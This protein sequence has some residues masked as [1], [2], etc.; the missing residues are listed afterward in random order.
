MSLTLKKIL[1][2]PAFK[3][4]AVLTG[5]KGLSRAVTSVSFVDAPDGSDWLKGGEIL[6]TSGY[7]LKNDLA[8]FGRLIGN[9][10][11]AKAAALFIKMKGFCGHLPREISDI[12]DGLNFPIIAMPLHCTYRDV[13]NQVLTML[14]NEH[15]RKLEISGTIHRSFIDLILNGGGMDQIIMLLSQL[16][17]SDVAYID[18]KYKHNYISAHLKTFIQD[19]SELNFKKLLLKYKNYS[20]KMDRENYGY[21]VC[22]NDNGGDIDDEYQNIAIEHAST[23]LKLEIQKKIAHTEI[24]NRY[25]NEFVQDV[26]LNNIKSQTELKN[27][28]DLY[29]WSDENGLCV[30]VAEIDNFN[31][32]SLLPKKGSPATVREMIFNICA[33]IM[34]DCFNSVLA[35]YCS[36]SI[37]FMIEP[38][39]PELN[40]FRDKLL[41][42]GDQIR[43]KVHDKTGFTLIV[44]ISE[45]RQSLQE[46]HLSYKE[47]QNTVKLGKM[48]YKRN[49]TIFYNDLKVYRLL[50]PISNTQ[51]A[52][53]FCNASI[54]LLRK[55]D[56]RRGTDLYKTLICI[57]E[58]NWNLKNAAAMMYIHYNTIKYRYRKIAEILNVDLEDIEERFIIS[59]SIKLIR[60]ID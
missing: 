2:M 5:K 22:S 15:V 52:K 48:L 31:E 57:N 30:V 6:M 39:M 34:E 4:F 8:Q 24:E 12:A 21:I 10:A 1:E 3:E 56:E 7:I 9:I 11:H 14:I 45:Y 26:L 25:K 41:G 16:I 19:I 43:K 18:I 51:E 50:D 60:M 32:N 29:G 20:V 36:D 28:A 38:S 17:H 33:A 40:D 42:A 58:C 49:R 13:T 46:A 37:V 47:A 55:H 54:G 23:A 27:R 35:T 44:G 59:M 53:E